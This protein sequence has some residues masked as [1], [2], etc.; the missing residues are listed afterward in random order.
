M[1][2]KG[3]NKTPFPLSEASVFYDAAAGVVGR[4]CSILLARY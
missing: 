2:T 3:K 4:A 1:K